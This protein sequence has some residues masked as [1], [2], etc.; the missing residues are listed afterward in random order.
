MNEHFSSCKNWT[1]EFI[2]CDIKYISNIIKI[3]KFHLNVLFYSLVFL[4]IDTNIIKQMMYFN[5][6]FP[7]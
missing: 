4:S 5:A 2:Q 6:F 1:E 7:H 3:F